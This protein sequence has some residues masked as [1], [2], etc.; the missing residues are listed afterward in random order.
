M[1]TEGTLSPESAAAATEA[2]EAAGPTAQQVVREAAKAME[3]DREE[4]GEPPV[5]QLVN[6]TYS[7]AEMFAEAA[8][9]TDSFDVDAFEQAVLGL[10]MEFGSLANGYGAKFDADLHRNQ[11]VRVGGYQWQPDEY[12]DDVFHPEQNDGTLDVYGVHPEEAKF[13]F[14]SIEDIPRPDYT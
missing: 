9:N 8:A 13:D 1:E 5:S 14:I 12:T 6:T 4:Y 10:D 2:F 7:A 3:F 11:R